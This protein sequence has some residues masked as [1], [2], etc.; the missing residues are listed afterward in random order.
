MTSFLQPSQCFD[1]PA[2]YTD[3]RTALESS[4]QSM[5]QAI[6]SLKFISHAITIDTT[7]RLAA[8]YQKHGRMPIIDDPPSDGSD[9][10]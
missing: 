5:N 10:S 9:D 4:L 7:H 6:D 2:A 3:V 1:T 8:R